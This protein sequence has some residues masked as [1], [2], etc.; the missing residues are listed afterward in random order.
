MSAAGNRAKWS[1]ATAAAALVALA[2]TAAPVQ[3]GPVLQLAG[4]YLAGLGVGAV[5]FVSLLTVTGAAWHAPFQAVPLRLAGCFPAAAILLLGVVL[6][7]PETYPWATQPEPGLRGQWLSRDFFAVRTA[8]YLA[9]W[10]LSA[11]YLARWPGSVPVAAAVL[12][13]LA[14]TAWLAAGDWLMSLTPGWASTIFGLYAFLGFA[15]ST[16]A[17]L[18][19]TACA[20]RIAGGHGSAVSSA[21]ITDLAGFLF[22]VTALWAYTW[23]CQYMLTWYT[24]QPHEIG[25]FAARVDGSW[26]WPFFG[27]VVLGWGLPFA[28][29]LSSAARRRPGVVLVAAAS[30]LAG[31]WLDLYALIG[32]AVANVRPGA[33]L[34]ALVLAAIGVA[35]CGW[36]LCDRGRAPRDPVGNEAGTTMSNRGPG[37]PGTRAS[38]A[39]RS[40]QPGAEGL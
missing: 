35:W 6:A 14:P 18:A 40:R 36:L 31:H 28:L 30:V 19:I 10:I 20:A 2:G 21:Q 1:G 13:V 29:L 22:A 4:V 7:Y 38:E 34:P 17:A 32:P 23:Y 12:V 37:V 27:A 15:A 33:G 11:R 5:F 26:R 25:Y 3:A 24:N 16:V 39:C 8:V 9:A